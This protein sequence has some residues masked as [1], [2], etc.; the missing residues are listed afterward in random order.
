MKLNNTFFQ[1]QYEGKVM[2]CIALINKTL[3]YTRHE[4]GTSVL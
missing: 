3:I 2:I 4:P 1:M